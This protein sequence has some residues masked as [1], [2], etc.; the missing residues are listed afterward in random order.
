LV[1]I[2]VSRE[3]PVISRGKN[4]FDAAGKFAASQHDPVTAG[5]ALQANIRAETGNIPLESTTGMR[6]AHADNI[7]Q[8]K[9]RKHG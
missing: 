5:A 9:V 7:V 6:L 1:G 8:L 4:R 2:F 3:V